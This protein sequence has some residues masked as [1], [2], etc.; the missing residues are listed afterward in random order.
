MALPSAPGRI[1]VLMLPPCGLARRLV[2]TAPPCGPLRAPLT[3]LTRSV[4]LTMPTLVRQR[5]IPETQAEAIA[6]ATASPAIA[7]LSKARSSFKESGLCSS[8]PP[9][10]NCPQK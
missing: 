3:A 8:A 7:D 4:L 10:Q 1:R 2:R 9:S 6:E 5:S